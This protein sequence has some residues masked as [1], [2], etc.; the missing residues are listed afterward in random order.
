MITRIN[1]ALRPY[2]LSYSR[3]LHGIKLAGVE[4]DRSVLAEVALKS[5]EDFAQLVVLAKQH[6]A[7]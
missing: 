6:L 4:L 2:N 3:F 5:P 7:S 1:A